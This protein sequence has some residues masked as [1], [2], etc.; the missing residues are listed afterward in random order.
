[1]QPYP[2][3]QYVYPNAAPMPVRYMIPPGQRQPSPPFANQAFN[4]YATVPANVRPP[5]I[6]TQPI[7]YPP[8]YAQPG[9]QMP[10][11]PPQQR[12]PPEQLRPPQPYYYNPYGSNQET[13]T[14]SP[15]PKTPA[16]KKGLKEYKDNAFTIAPDGAQNETIKGLVSNNDINDL[17]K[18]KGTKVKVSKIY[19]I[20]KT[21]PDIKPDESS[22]EDLPPIPVAQARP[23]TIQRPVSSSSS[24]SSSC[25]HCSTCSNCSCSECRDRYRSH[26]YDDC[27][28]CRAERDREQA[29]RQRRK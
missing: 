1:M 27:P 8:V 17:L 25:S 2:Y 24:S 14:A 7:R 19:R 28:E 5:Q 10:Y 6:M 21:K 3:G 20:T 15:D 12:Q 4:H 18:H 9:M 22:D 23:Q 11:G 26:T 29:R 16:P 13:S